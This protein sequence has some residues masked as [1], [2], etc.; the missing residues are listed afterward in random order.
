STPSYEVQ[1]NRRLHRQNAILAAIRQG[2][3]VDEGS[4]TIGVY[5]IHYTLGGIRKS[6]AGATSQAVADDSAKK[7]YID[8]S[9]TLQI[10]DSFPAALSSYLPLATVVTS[11]AAMSIVDERPSVLFTVA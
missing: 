6:F 10:Q 11:Q 2:M 3:V 5:P 7:V 4:L 1:Y 8:S 9:N